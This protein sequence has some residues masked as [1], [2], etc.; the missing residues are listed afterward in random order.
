V[1]IF[2]HD[3]PDVV[4]DSTNFMQVAAGYP[5]EHG[6]RNRRSEEKLGNA[7]ARLRK[8]AIGDQPAYFVF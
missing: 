4:G 7:H 2:L 1:R 8:T 5:E 3:L 6:V